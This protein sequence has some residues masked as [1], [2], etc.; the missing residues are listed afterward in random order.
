MSEKLLTFLMASYNG[1]KHLR[2]TLDSVFA[3]VS[4]ENLDDIEFIFIND[5]SVDKTQ[6]IFEEY[7]RN[8]DF[9]L[10]KQENLGLEA[11]QSKLF[12]LATGKYVYCIDH[13]DYLEPQAID[14]IIAFLRNTPESDLLLF[15]YNEFGNKA[16]AGKSR[17]GGCELKSKDGQDAFVQLMKTGIYII[18]LWNK[19]MLRENVIKNGIFETDEIGL[20]IELAPKIFAVSKQ[21]EYLPKALY[22]YGVQNG[23]YS[24]G[25]RFNP[26]LT[27]SRLHAL[28][29][30]TKL[31]GERDDLKPEF[32]EALYNEMSNLYMSALSGVRHD[33]KFD[34]PQLK[35]LKEYSWL[36]KYGKWDRK[37]I[38]SPIIKIFGTKAFYFLRFGL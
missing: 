9:T 18:P 19:V 27:K 8:Y 12:N 21:V 35:R 34:E 36:M 37:Y 30:L 6:E 11:T 26:R 33:G 16:E 23:S 10:I 3:A 5:G 1:E 25:K 29:S 20:D 32:T 22:N 4:D 31:L 15:D 13:D 17:K 2:R 38:Y 28:D 14:T 7:K 24:R